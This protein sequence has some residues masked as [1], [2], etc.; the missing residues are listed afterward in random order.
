MTTETSPRFSLDDRRFARRVRNLLAALLLLPVLSCTDGGGGFADN[1]GMSGTGISDGEITAFGSIFVGAVRWTLLSAAVELDGQT[2]TEADLRLGM[3]VRVEGDFD[4]GNTSGRALRVRYDP[5][6]EGPI[7]AAPIETIPGVEKSVSIL[8]RTVI[9]DATR[10][11]F[12]D[13]ADFGTLATDDVVEVS[14]LADDAGTIQAT[15][16]RSRGVYPAV[17]EVELRDEVTNLVKNPDGSGIFDLGAITVRYA[18]TTPFDDL[19]RPALQN[20]VRVAVEG[21]LRPSGDEVDATLVERAERGFGM[22]DLA[23]AEI[24]GLVVNCPTAPDFCVRGVPVDTSSAVFEPVGFVP[25]AG[26]R[27]EVEG[28]VVAGVLIAEE[29]EDESDDPVDARLEGAVTS[30][31]SGANTLTLLGVTVLVDGSTRLRDDSD[32]EDE[33]FTFEEI[34]V[35]NYLTVRGLEEGGDVR[36]RLIRRDDATP[37]ADDV[38]LQGPVTALDRI[39]PAISVLGQPIPLDAGTLYFDALGA[40]RSEEEFFRTPGDVMLGDVIA[41]QDVDAASL[42]TLSEADEVEIED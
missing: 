17:D 28:S 11:V 6:L 31:D 24:E 9:I 27:V 42:S 39:T 10:T 33:S 40:P 16:V 23:R 30:I 37:G 25:M 7:E 15:R 8:G 2:A 20:G 1:G 3:V 22:A 18:T 13:G 12:A 36:A 29:V 32:V 4:P 38:R 34:E 41:V 35:G 21:T 5:E 19:T 26:D 14:G